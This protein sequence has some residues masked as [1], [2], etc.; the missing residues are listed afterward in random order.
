LADLTDLLQELSGLLGR[1]DLQGR[2]CAALSLNGL[3]NSIAA[4]VGKFVKN[5]L[6]SLWPP[7]LNVLLSSE[8]VLEISL[9]LGVFPAGLGEERFG[10]RRK[11]NV[12]GNE[13]L[14]F[15]GVAK[16]VAAE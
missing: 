5:L 4:E 15:S 14:V 10:V 11:E 8:V 1:V 9:L 7:V 3:C 2:V 12:G 13:V 16:S 6:V